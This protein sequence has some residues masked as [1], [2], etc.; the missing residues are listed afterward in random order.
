MPNAPLLCPGQSL[1]AGYRLVRVRGQGAFGQVWEAAADDGS[2]VALKFL[3][4]RSDQAAALEVRNLLTI[5]RLSHPHLLPMQR[6]W[7]DRGCVVA[8]MELADGSLLDLLEVSLTEFGIPL[9]ADQVCHYLA[10]AAA[11]LDFLNARRHQLGGLRAGI[12]HGDVKP[13]NLLLFGEAV[14][15]CDFGLASPTAADLVTLRPAGT[16]AYA[17]PEVFRG[18]RS[19]WTDQYA[20]AVSYCELRGGRLPFRDMPDRFRAGY[21]RPQPD[22]SMVTPVERPVLARA[23]ARTPQDRWPSCGDLL[24]RLAAALPLARPAAS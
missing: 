21:V 23:L 1:R 19:R 5:S 15:V 13:S 11:A 16:L 24:A 2:T 6:V 8:V 14:R 10:Q 22:L 18:Q 17:A 9:P 12:Q 3:P 20:L 4:C 7:A